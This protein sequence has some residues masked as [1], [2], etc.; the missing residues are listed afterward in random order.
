MQSFHKEVPL[1]INI[2][3]LGKCYFDFRSQLGFR[4]DDITLR[5][6]NA[7]CVTQIPSNMYIVYQF[8][9]YYKG[10]RKKT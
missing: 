2:D 8:T 7:I 9:S 3:R 1:S 6:F 4:T 10:R 5:D